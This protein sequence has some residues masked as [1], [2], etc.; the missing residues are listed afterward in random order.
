MTYPL[1]EGEHLRRAVNWISLNIAEHPGSP[2]ASL[3]DQA[4]FRFDLT[5]KDG[6]YL[7]R[8]FRSKKSSG[9]EQG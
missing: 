1:P 6:E 3:V 8:L 9:N 7:M 2:L 4:I 5:P